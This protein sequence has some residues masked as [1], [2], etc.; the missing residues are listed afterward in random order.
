MIITMHGGLDA[1]TSAA[2][3]A[4]IARKAGFAG[5]ELRIEKCWDGYL[6][7]CGVPMIGAIPVTG[8]GYDMNRVRAAVA[9]ANY[10]G[11][12][13]IQVYPE[14]TDGERLRAAL[15]RMSSAVGPGVTLAFEPVGFSPLSFEEQVGA[16]RGVPRV[17]LVLDT[18]HLYHL[19]CPDLSRVNPGEIAYAHLGDGLSGGTDD[20][21][22]TV[23]PGFGI[24]P[25]QKLVEEIKGTGYEGPWGVE[26]LG[27]NAALAPLMWKNAQVLLR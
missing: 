1:A 23:A 13:F 3:D 19:N 16:A 15:R 8:Y 26:V 2:E 14:I 4:I 24:V 20:A 11:S 12:R 6:P 27:V 21:L 10:M 5:V 17:R 7:D 18:W 9:F 25:L 22:R